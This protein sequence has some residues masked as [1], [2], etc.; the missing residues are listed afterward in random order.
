MA[1]DSVPGMVKLCP[2]FIYFLP[3]DLIFHKIILGRNDNF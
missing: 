2:F 3:P 1:H